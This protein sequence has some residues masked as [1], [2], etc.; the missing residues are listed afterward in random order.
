MFALQIPFCAICWLLWHLIMRVFYYH[1]HILFFSC[2][3]LLLKF[4]SQ[5]Q[6]EQTDKE[7]AKSN[8]D[9]GVEEGKEERF[10]SSLSYLRSACRLQPSNHRYWND[11]G[12]AEMRIKNYKIAQK[13]FLKA[14]SI[15]P[16][17]SLAK[18]NLENLKEFLP[19]D[20]LAKG[21]QEF[22]G[23][24]QLHKVKPMKELSHTHP[25]LTQN[26]TSTSIYHYDILEEPFIIKKAV[27]KWNWNLSAF[28]IDYLHQVFGSEVV[29]YYPGNMLLSGATRL[30]FMNFSKA[31]N[32]QISLRGIYDATDA[33]EPGSYIQWNMAPKFADLVFKQLNG[34]IPSVFDNKFW[35]ENCFDDPMF[36]DMYHKNTHVKMILHGNTGAGM[37]NHQDS[38]HGASF[39]I[40][41]IGRKKWHLCADDQSKY[42]YSTS[43]NIDAFGPDYETYPEYLKAECYQ[44]V[45]EPGDLLYYPKRFWH[46]TVNLDPD[47]VA[48]SHTMV[49]PQNYKN[50]TTFL[51]RSCEGKE[52]MFTA[53][54]EFCRQLN[55][56]Y[57]LW[58]KRFGNYYINR[59]SADLNFLNDK[60]DVESVKNTASL[61]FVTD[62]L[63]DL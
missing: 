45:T 2:L 9:F 37:F 3:L 4:S 40:Q 14:L 42:L 22:N 12:V 26:A 38:L 36:A 21:V 13:R 47:S 46:Q 55:K 62:N 15:K 41:L 63:F 58:D 29:D 50:V 32:E 52:H 31:L 19:Q 51:Q 54:P 23:F 11:L 34:Y 7:L 27:Q 60:V 1:K 28:T 49:T 48:Y 56:C 25:S 30:Y 53:D 18:K 33:S 35:T 24:P 20:V 8:H 6:Q 44:F 16:K 10:S 59:S 61:D 5:Q 57:T 43:D 39:Q 17:Y